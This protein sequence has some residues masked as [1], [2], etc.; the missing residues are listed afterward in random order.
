MRLSQS[1]QEIVKL[2][3]RRGAMTAD[4]LS[5]EIGI[6]SVAVRQHLEVLEAEGLLGSRTERRP[7]G[8]P[9][10]LFHLTEAADELFPKNYSGL[11]QILL[12]YLESAGG[13]CQ[14]EDAFRFRRERLERDL[15][16]A[17][18]GRDLESRLA[19]VARMQDEAGYMA[20][21][22]KDEDGS[23]LLREHNCAICKIARRFPQA[24]AEELRLIENVTGAEVVREQHIAGGDPICSYRIRP[25]SLN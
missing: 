20:E 24:C 4:D 23:Y 15:L 17:V 7:I 18:E 1:Q 9:R 12:E 11:A 3:R 6:S 8:R 25:R 21:W 16:P 5:Q 10:R 2:L 22:E 13:T 14:V 19:A